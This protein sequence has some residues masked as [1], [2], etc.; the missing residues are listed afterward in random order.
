MKIGEVS[1]LTGDV[2]RLANFYK[3]LF[4]IE[5]KDNDDVH[6]VIITDGTGLT[7]YNDGVERKNNY[8]NICLAFTVDSVDEEFIRLQS[9]GV[10][11]IEPPTVR[12]WGAKN[13][14]FTDPDGNRIVFRSLL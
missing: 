7:I 8:Q 10:E 4:G 14:I 11:I 13:V 9:L 5:N 3:K 6:Q 2:I 12:P 1:L